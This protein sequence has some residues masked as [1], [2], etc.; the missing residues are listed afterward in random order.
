MDS[1]NAGA[2]NKV[3][4]TKK[5][6]CHTIASIAIGSISCSPEMWYNGVGHSHVVSAGPSGWRGNG[7]NW[8][9]QEVL[10]TEPQ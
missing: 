8:P 10:A 5:T 3:L 1:T 2:P 6:V 7:T 4:V 9:A